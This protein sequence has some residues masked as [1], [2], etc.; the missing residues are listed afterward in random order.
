MIF[1]WGNA[2]YG[3]QDIIDNPQWRFIKA[4]REKRVYKLPEW[5]TWSPRLALV[6]LWMAQKAYP[7][8]FEDISFYN[9]ADNFY[10]KLFN[11]PCNL[12]ENP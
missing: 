9:V 6:A 2:G 11:I 8:D 5:T 12:Q 10:R 4:V 7:E 1:I 3:A